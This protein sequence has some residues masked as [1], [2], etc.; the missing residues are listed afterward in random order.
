MRDELIR[1]FE[2]QRNDLER[3]QARSMSALLSEFAALRDQYDRVFR[4]LAGVRSTQEEHTREHAEILG[5]LQQI[6]QRQK[7][8]VTQSAV[9]SLPSP[10]P[11][12]TDSERDIVDQG[13][14]ERRPSHAGCRGPVA[15]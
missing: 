12:L 2:S 8:Q 15:A 11:T 1:L 9:E 10:V 7:Q 3:E 5:L 6:N 14:A 4:A 13:P